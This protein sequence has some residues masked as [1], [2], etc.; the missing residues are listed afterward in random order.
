MNYSSIDG[1]LFDKNQSI[2]LCYPSGKTN[3]TYTIPSSVTSIADDALC[4]F[5]LES[6]FFPYNII[7][8]GS[9]SF[10]TYFSALY[11]HNGSD[12]AKALSKAGYGFREID[13]KYSLKYIFEDNTITGIE[14][15]CVDKDITSLTIPS[16]VTSIGDYT[17]KDCTKLS[18]VAIPNSITNI[19]EGSFFNCSNLTEIT[20]P[21]SVINIGYAAFSGCSSLKNITLSSNVSSIDSYTFSGCTQLTSIT[22]PSQGNRLLRND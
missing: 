6:V 11:A 9:F 20:V 17:F 3:S 22:I 2:L 10:N 12:T 7:S 8:I 18:S 5:R 4:C 14:L 21:D 13:E 1:I 19:G 15:Y 16:Q